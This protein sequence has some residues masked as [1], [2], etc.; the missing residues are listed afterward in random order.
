MS[1]EG[2]ITGWNAGAQ[3]MKQYKPEEVLGQHFSML[4]PEEDAGATSRW[5]TSRRLPSR[6]VSAGRA[7]ACARTASTSSPTSPSPPSTPSR[8]CAASAR[9]CRT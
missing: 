5:R 1:P 7:S 9:S 2:N 8:S 6:G 4:Y 3:R